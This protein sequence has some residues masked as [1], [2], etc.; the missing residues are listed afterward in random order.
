M[1]ELTLDPVP[2]ARLPRLVGLAPLGTGMPTKEGFPL[3]TW[4][5][6]SG[7]SALTRE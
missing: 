2:A 3:E 6:S 5:D 1:T 4:L 7:D